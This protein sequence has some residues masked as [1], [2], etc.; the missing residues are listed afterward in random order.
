M[1]LN[2]QCAVKIGVWFAVSATRIMRPIFFLWSIN[3]HW[4]VTYTYS[5]SILC[6]PVGLQENLCVFFCETVQ[7]LKP[8]IILCIGWRVFLATE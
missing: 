5:D 3:W 1:P 6:S 7:K 4:Y 2:P 8:Q